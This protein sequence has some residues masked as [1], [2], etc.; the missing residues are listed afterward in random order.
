L[1]GEVR[2]VVLERL[3][4]VAEAMRRTEDINGAVKLPNAVWRRA[5][6][7]VSS[8]EAACFLIDIVP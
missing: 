4:D 5:L 1:E 6:S 7:Y 2:V 3:E 8:L